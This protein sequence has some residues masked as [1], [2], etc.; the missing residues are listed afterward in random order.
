MEFESL[1]KGHLGFPSDCCDCSKPLSQVIF[2]L[3]PLKHV[4]CSSSQARYYFTEP[5]ITFL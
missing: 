3:K 2:A 1:K 5:I 4:L